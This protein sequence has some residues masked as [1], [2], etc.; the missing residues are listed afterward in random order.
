MIKKHMKIIIALLMILTLC[1][2]FISTVK[3]ED[4][5]PVLTSENEENA[6]AIE[7]APLETAPVDN[8]IVKNDLYLIDQEV[9]MDKIVDG[10]VYIMANKAKITGK[11]NGNIYIMANEISFEKP[12]NDAVADD[13]CYIAGS[14]YILGNTIK[15]DGVAQDIYAMG[16]SFNMSYNSYILR[17]VKVAGESVT[18]KGYITRNV[19]M[20]A[21][22]IDL[23]TASESEN[24][25]DSV[26]I[27]GNLNYTAP[28]AVTIPENR[29]I[30]DVKFTEDKTDNKVEIKLSIGDIIWK[31]AKDLISTI[32]Y[33]LLFF[34]IINWLAPKFF[35]KAVVKE[36]LGITIGTGAIVTLVPP[37]L[38][39]I[40]FFIGIFINFIFF[41]VVLTFITLYGLL[42]AFTFALAAGSLTYAFKDK[43]GFGDKKWLFLLIVTLVLWIALQIPFV[44]GLAWL[45][46]SFI[47]SG[48]LIKVLLNNAKEAKEIK[49]IKE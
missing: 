7:T 47:A 48:S 32:V 38:F 17:D 5:A 23:G 15:F 16:S 24:E 12:E 28:K 41:E 21:N 14:A 36:K 35:K 37:I 34:L 43:F 25:D 31:Y 6:E 18:L 1:T 9:T 33:T 29:V 8:D 45:A 27:G 2:A 11:V 10:N 19:D 42:I 49:E 3:A 4:E 22:K 44:N 46:I 30:G 13:Y 20:A 26:M 40:L 39:F